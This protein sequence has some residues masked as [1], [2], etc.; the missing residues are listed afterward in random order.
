MSNQDTDDDRRQL[1][2]IAESCLATFGSLC[3]KV[4][5]SDGDEV[6]NWNRIREDVT[7][8]VNVYVYA[9]QS[10]DLS[11]VMQRTGNSP[12]QYHGCSVQKSRV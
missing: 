1:V 10:P 4:N 5:T 2:A 7:P 11:K 8:L 12:K 6:G 9:L 3:D